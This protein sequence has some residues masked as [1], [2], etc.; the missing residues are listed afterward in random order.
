MEKE[1]V[2]SNECW[3]EEKEKDLSEG[4]NR[5]Q[6]SCRAFRINQPSLFVSINL[7]GGL[8]S[9]GDMQ[10]PNCF[11]QINTFALFDASTDPFRQ[12]YLVAS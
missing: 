6:R 1:E 10:T 11:C 4:Y 8:I 2:F 7:S 5:S 3:G 9:L 12:S